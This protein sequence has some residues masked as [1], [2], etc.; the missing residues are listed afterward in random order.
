MGLFVLMQCFN[1][2]SL[3]I[4]TIVSETNS[5]VGK[6]IIIVNTVVFVHGGDEH[7]FFL[8]PSINETNCF[9]HIQNF[10]IKPY[11][12]GKRLSQIVIKCT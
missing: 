11:S 3:K 2:I 1:K 9:M 6:N 10:G 5:K 8:S 12:K 4:Q 7:V